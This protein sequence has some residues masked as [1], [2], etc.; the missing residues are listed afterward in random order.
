[1]IFAFIALYIITYFAPDGLAYGLCIEGLISCL[2]IT[3]F[4]KTPHEQYAEKASWFCVAICMVLNAVFFTWFDESYILSKEVAIIE[5]IAFL[6]ML[7]YSHYRSYKFKSDDYNEEDTFII[8]KR[9]KSTL[10]FLFSCVLHPVSS[11]SIASRG[12]WYRFKR[13]ECFKKEP[14]I[15]KPGHILIK[16]NKNY[17]RVDVEMKPFIG[18]EW[19]MSEN[20]CDVIQR[21]FPSQRFN[22]F[23]SIPACMSRKI[24]KMR[25]NN[26]N[27]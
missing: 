13:G 5:S 15:R 3:A 6:Y 11:M 23:D 12:Q 18:N 17:E 26:G 24:I 27:S 7:L 21:L 9:P 20:C 10:D 22:I 16:V 1:M 8:L 25:Y 19:N 14:Y 2:A 4:L